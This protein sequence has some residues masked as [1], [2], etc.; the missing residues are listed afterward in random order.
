MANEREELKGKL[1]LL[2]IEDLRNDLEP[3]PCP[4]AQV[5]TEPEAEEVMRLARFIKA[6]LCPS[7]GPAADVVEY[8]E[9]LTDRAFGE[10]GKKTK[11]GGAVLQQRKKSWLPA[12]YR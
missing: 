5:L 1:L 9:D 11:L 10:L 4:E 2:W 6:V 8:A 7:E 12:I 3:R